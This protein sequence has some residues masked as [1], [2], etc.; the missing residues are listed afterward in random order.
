ME[1]RIADSSKINIGVLIPVSIN[2]RNKKV[3]AISIKV[4]VKNNMV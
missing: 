2:F 3:N 4:S 1:N